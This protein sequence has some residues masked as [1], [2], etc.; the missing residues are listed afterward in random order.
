[1]PALSY[2]RAPSQELKALLSP[3]GFLK[4]LLGLNERRVAGLGLDV[5]LRR[6]DEVHLYCG[7]T[8]ILTVSRNSDGTVRI[9]ADQAYEEQ[10]CATSVMRRW[11]TDKSGQFE[12]A[13]NAYL[14]EVRVSDSFVSNEGQVQYKWSRVNHPW[15]P[16]DREAVFEKQPTSS[17]M[18]AEIDAA[19]AELSRQK[20]WSAEVPADRIGQG[21]ID[22]LAVDKK[23]RLVLLELKSTSAHPAGIYYSPLQLL[24]YTWAWYTNLEYLL[25]GVQDLIDARV[26]LGLTSSQ[27]LT[28]SGGLR[29]AI[30]FGQDTRSVEVKRRFNMVLSV[31]NGHLPPGV[32][33]IE[34][35]ALDNRLDPVQLEES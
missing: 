13:L 19:C 32:P 3:G 21:E 1:M 20:D 29:V 9:S 7:L 35:W 17:R 30:G 14:D 11:S 5:H 25:D 26:E 34:V 6:S 22:Q 28:L 24:A 23:G 31:M 15:I 4:P 8:R 16:F 12:E 10:E 2:G 18:S 27:I 33:P